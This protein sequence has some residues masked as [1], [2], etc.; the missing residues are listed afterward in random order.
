MPVYNPVKKRDT[1]GGGDSFPVLAEGKYRGKVIG[2]E[3][4][5]GTKKTG[6]NAGKPWSADQLTIEFTDEGVTKPLRV[7][8]NSKVQTELLEAVGVDTTQAGVNYGK[9]DVQGQTLIFYVS[10]SKDGKFNN[11]EGVRAVPVRK[12][13]ITAGTPG[14]PS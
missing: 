1:E 14:T 5:S 11:V 13:G 6:K 9:D 12:A 4:I 2:Y 8:H 3:E 10:V 7:F